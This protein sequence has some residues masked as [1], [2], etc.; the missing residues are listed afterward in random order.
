MIADSGCQ[1]SI[2]PWETAVSMG[3]TMTDIMPVSLSMRGAIKEDLGVEGGIIV[4]ITVRN[5]S[6]ERSCRQLVYLSR[7]MNKA[8][9]CREAMEQ[10]G[11]IPIA[12]PDNTSLCSSSLST[13]LQPDPSC[14]CPK[15]TTEPPPL[16][17]T[18]PPGLSG[19]DGPAL[20]EWLLSY[21]GATA[22]NTCEHQPLPMMKGEPLRLFTN[23]DAK[24]VAVH[25]PAIVPIHWRDQVY[26]GLE[27]D[28]ALGVLERVDTNTPAESRYAPVE[29][30]AL[31]IAYAII[32]PVSI[33]WDVPACLL[34]QTTS[35]SSKS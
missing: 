21:Y 27:R 30:E 6:T 24:P 15:Q 33:S 29:G 20:K 22:F 13:G 10:L 11:I 14:N 26:A 31:A 17:K 19:T 18:L 28:V 9:L 32:K 3:Y 1:S 2:I 5:N 16:P 34:P 7:K 4:K 23:P 25:N 8:F 12:F 35:R